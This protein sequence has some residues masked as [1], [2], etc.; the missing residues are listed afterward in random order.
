[1]TLHERGVRATSHFA[2]D[3]EDAVAYYLER[4]GKN[5]AL[6]FLAEYDRF[7]S[8]VASLPGYGPVVG[9]TNLRWRKLGAFVAIY[10]ENT[11][12]DEIV[13]LRLYH[14]S[15]NWRSHVLGILPTDEA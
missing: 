12:S 3:F 7:R 10:Y 5:S 6:K 2:Q 9:D 15:S 4:V 1:M 13:L 14:L 11:S 8:L